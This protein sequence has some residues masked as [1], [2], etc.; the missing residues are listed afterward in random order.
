MVQAYSEDDE[1]TIRAMWLDGASDASIGKAV[2][3][4]PKAV[5]AK[6]RDM[7]LTPENYPERRIRVTWQGRLSN[8]SR[9]V[10][11]P[12]DEKDILD[13]H[14]RGEPLA[15]IAARYNVIQHT[16]KVKLDRLLELAEEEPRPLV[17]RACLGGCG[18]SFLSREPKKLKRICPNCMEQLGKMPAG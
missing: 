1:A 2:D 6:R 9:N 3:R 4:S 10:Y 17:P 15:S 18:R 5:R 7:C 11:T 8:V 12:E 16:M 14:E 13:S